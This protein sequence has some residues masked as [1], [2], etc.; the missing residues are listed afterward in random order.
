MNVLLR[1]FFSG[2]L[3]DLA[4]DLGTANT[5]VYH[6]DKGIIVNEPSVVAVSSADEIEDREVLAIGNKAK[7][8][9]GKA[10]QSI[11]VI[12]PIKDGVIADFST[13]E[14]MLKHFI[15]KAT[16]KRSLFRPRV[17]I[18]IPSG[19]TEVEKRAV[20]ESALSAGAREVFLVEE[21]VAA[22][23]GAGLPIMEPSGNMIV[24]I[25][26][27]TTE[28][29]LIS[30]GGIVI[31]NSIRTA[32]DQMDEALVTHMKKKYSL[33]IGDTTAETIKMQYGE[34]FPSDVTDKVSLK[35]RDLIR[36]I[37]RTVQITR[38]EIRE[39]LQEPIRN[40][41]EAIRQTL[42]K[43]PP[44]LASDIHDHGI[45]LTG[46]VAQLKNLDKLIHEETGLPV[47]L[48]ENPLLSVVMGTGKIL[49]DLETYQ[50]VLIRRQF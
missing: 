18:C 25:G 47:T 8:M 3:H 4:I 50:S 23:I 33:L 7:E 28:V 1:S 45:V 14:A 49:S 38:D 48:A 12:R 40:I 39:S 20:E 6:Q 42:E 22:A 16:S 13:T 36:G 19:V 26:G 27:G 46:G 24:D 35:G 44:E 34:A 2:F 11:Q 32:G 5:L 29:A 30:L 31:A 41:I 15:A 10:P 9:A 43:T 21:P 17:A 37:P